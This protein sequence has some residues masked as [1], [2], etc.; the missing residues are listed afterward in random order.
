MAEGD[1]V[2]LLGSLRRFAV[3]CGN[4][5]FAALIRRILR[6]NFFAAPSDL[7]PA[8]FFVLI[9]VTI[10]KAFVR[11]AVEAFCI[12]NISIYPDKLG[13]NHAFHFSSSLIARNVFLAFSSTFSSMLRGEL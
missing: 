3:S 11:L 12:A 9:S 13:L 5:E 1:P 4:H 8:E 10:I 2:A 6:G 7:V